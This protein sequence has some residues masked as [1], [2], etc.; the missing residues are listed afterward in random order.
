[1]TRQLGTSTRI[2]AAVLFAFLATGFARAIADPGDPPPLAGI[3]HVAIRVHNL[4]AS[5]KFYQALGFDQP[6]NLSRDGKLYEAFV[7]I[8]DT[9][10]IELYPVTA[11]DAQA[12]LLHLC[13]EA[14]DINAVYQDYTTRGLTPRTAVRKAGA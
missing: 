13:F 12:G 3:A 8:N 5:A 10:F 9:Q 7:K 1:M 14:A 4:D 2:A 6:F 11:K